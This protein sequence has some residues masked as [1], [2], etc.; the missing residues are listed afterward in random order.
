[1]ETKHMPHRIL[2]LALAMAFAAAIAW[3]QEDKPQ[4]TETKDTAWTEGTWDPKPEEHRGMGC[5]VARI[6]DPA[7]LP[8]GPWATASPGDLLVENDLVRAVVSTGGISAR[9]GVGGTGHIVDICLRET[10]WDSFGTLTQFA[11]AG[12]MLGQITYERVEMQPEEPG[13][14]PP[15][16]VAYGSLGDDK[17]FIAVTV[18][19]A[20]PGQPHIAVKTYLT[21]RST[22]PQ[23]VA[24]ATKAHWGGLPVFAGDYGV[25]PLLSQPVR[26]ATP[27]V[28][29]FQD[30]FALGLVRVAQGPDTE[31]MLNRN[32]TFVPYG[33][34]VLQPG[35]TTHMD[36]ALVLTQ[37][38]MAPVCEFYLATRQAQY[39]I[40]RGKVRQAPDA[41]PLADVQIE[42]THARDR[43]DRREGD[44]AFPLPPYAIA[45]S[46]AQG[47]FAIMLPPAK[48]AVQCRTVARPAIP[49]VRLGFEIPA[50]Q[51]L[52]RDLDQVPPNIVTVE[53]ADAETGEPIPAKV[54]FLP[55]APT[56]IDL[57]PPWQAQGARD[58][59]YLRPGPN[60][61]HLGGGSY[62]CV[63]SRGPQY[64]AYEKNIKVRYDEPLSIRAKL[65]RLSDTP[66]WTH[67]ALGCATQ[68]SP[69]SRVSTE[70]L[71]LAAAGE[72]IEYIVTG[73]LNR[74]TDLTAAIRK[75]RLERWVRCASGVMLEYRHRR[76]FGDFF[77]FPLPP[78]T[79]AREFDELADADTS[80]ERFFRN[81]RKK[82]PEAIVC[83][84]SIAQV[85]R[86]YL[87]FYNADHLED[88]PASGK[89]FS[90]DFDAL[91]VYEGKSEALRTAAMSHWTSLMHAGK[92]K[93]PLALS[94]T[95]MLHYEEPGYPRMVV[96]IPKGKDLQSLSAQELTDAI[97]K[98]HYYM[99]NGPLLDLELNGRWPDFRAA[100]AGEQIEYKYSV[101]AAP[102]VA[103]DTIRALRNG[104][105]REQHRLLASTDFQ[106]FPHNEKAAARKKWRLWRHHR[107]TGEKLFEDIYFQIEVQGYGLHPTVSRTR[108]KVT[109]VYA[110]TAPFMFDADDNGKMEF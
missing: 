105:P 59:V 44:D 74:V 101:D 110:L 94:R 79:S 104:R 87:V 17:R 61:V 63:V 100:K 56:R 9:Q 64:A 53:A 45:R 99:T 107:K 103:V 8:G 37:G 85:D 5:R 13:K 93:L 24:L 78:D 28:C 62:R 31:V 109:P 106:R 81:V 32:E 18:I 86:S 33:G 60:R 1:M 22:E 20:I 29:G 98:G 21:N 82:W 57:G 15:S 51:L 108:N 47:R 6:L 46:D 16:V 40:L 39:G 68:A 10:M 54:R 77:V 97:R 66:G 95:P 92:P 89:H 42:I 35:Q 52:E 71:V 7:D 50:G 43:S 41:K 27:W 12:D 84:A 26:I 96:R 36:M 73:D 72:G 11:N 102:W 65:K 19:H 14:R 69:S 23:Q 88:K 75:M 48:Y 38:D 58:S 34:A 4:E 70:D 25:P 76:L 67:V 83:P 90:D 3:A 80:P 91:A 49:P 55:I 30:D 2:T